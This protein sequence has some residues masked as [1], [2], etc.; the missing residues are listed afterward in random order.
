[1]SSFVVFANVCS[2]FGFGCKLIM[3]EAVLEF[4]GFPV[5][6]RRANHSP[7]L[8]AGVEVPRARLR[9][10]RRLRT[11]R[12]FDPAAVHLVVL[13]GA[14]VHVVRL[15]GDVRVDVLEGLLRRVD[16]REPL[17]VGLEEPANRM[18]FGFGCRGMVK[19]E[20]A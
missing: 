14:D 17:L 7:V 5:S 15:E 6:M 18:V 3:F 13:V 19:G 4:L 9:L 16:L 11:P 2:V 8:C 10:S 1:M 20:T 12:A